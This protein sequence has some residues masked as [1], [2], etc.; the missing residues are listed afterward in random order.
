[1]FSSCD[2]KTQPIATILTTNMK[3]NQVICPVITYRESLQTINGYH[4]TSESC[5]L[6]LVVA[7]FLDQVSTSKVSF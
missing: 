6:L 5:S 3:T 2:R 4:I 1:M 7:L